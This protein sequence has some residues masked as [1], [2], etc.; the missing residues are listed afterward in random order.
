MV[1]LVTGPVYNAFDVQRGESGSLPVTSLIL[2]FTTAVKYDLPLSEE[3]VEYLEKI[4]PL[5]EF[6]KRYSPY[7]GDIFGWSI[8]LPDTSE[9]TTGEAMN[10]YLKFLFER[11]DVVIKDR[12]DGV[13]LVWDVFSHPGVN[14]DRYA[15]GIWGPAHLS[16]YAEQFPNVFFPDRQT[17]DDV[18]SV[19]DGCARFFDKYYVTAFNGTSII[20]SLLWRNGIYVIL[21]LLCI[22]VALKEKKY[23]VIISILPAIAI[24]M[25]LILV[26]SWQIYQ[27]V[28]FFPL[29]TMIVSL[30][31]LYDSPKN[32]ESEL[33][34]DFAREEIDQRLKEI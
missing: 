31:L 14:H 15:L 11:P 6:E 9:I 22:V 32:T 2:P 18:Y 34:I 33:A 26:I 7:N 5:E 1:Q 17:G 8:P 13:N 30:Y 28:Y 10:H 4:L 29:C 24:L 27:Y 25:T 16:D 20:N 12:L 19:G 21:V 3:T 23:R